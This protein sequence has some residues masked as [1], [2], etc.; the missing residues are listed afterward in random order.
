MR[1]SAAPLQVAVETAAALEAALSVDVPLVTHALEGLADHVLDPERDGT[2]R[3]LDAHMSRLRKK[4][5]SAGSVI[6]TVWGIGY[7]LTPDASEDSP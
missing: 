1:A 4:L 3:S 5:G 6:K 2:E 7:R